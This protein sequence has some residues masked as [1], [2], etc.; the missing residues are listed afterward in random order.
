MSRRNSVWDLNIPSHPI[1]DSVA[2][3]GLMGRVMIKQVS[4]QRLLVEVY[5]ASGG[6][7]SFVP[8]LDTS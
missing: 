2:V 1:A 6:V 7:S 8:A 4:P 3:V 5:R